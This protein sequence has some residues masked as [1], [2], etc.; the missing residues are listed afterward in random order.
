MRKWRQSVTDC[1]I[2]L[3]V[4]KVY[5]KGGVKF[6]NGMAS[7]H[8]RN[9]IGTK[10]MNQSGEKKRFF[11]RSD[12]FEPKLFK[13]TIILCKFYSDKRLIIL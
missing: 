2:I 7:R 3:L 11:G 8:F 9:I 13:S 1:D 10:K 5:M 4:N 6:F 12:P